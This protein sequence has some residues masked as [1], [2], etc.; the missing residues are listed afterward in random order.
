MKQVQ[1]KLH[2]ICCSWLDP[3][4]SLCRSSLSC[5][6]LKSNCH[7]LFNPVFCSIS[8][9]KTRVTTEVLPVS[10]ALLQGP[11][12]RGWLRATP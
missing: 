9:N 10:E 6:H 4:N 7:L 5:L 8:W 3:L 11:E 12:R 1:I 2:D